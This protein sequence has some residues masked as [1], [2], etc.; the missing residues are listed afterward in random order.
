M[1][2]ATRILTSCVCRGKPLALSSSFATSNNNPLAPSSQHVP[3]TNAGFLHPSHAK[4]AQSKLA[5]Q[6]GNDATSDTEE[7]DKSEVAED[8]EEMEVE[9]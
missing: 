6:G 1:F 9:M 8:D 5:T 4:Q 7:D 3:L 2:I